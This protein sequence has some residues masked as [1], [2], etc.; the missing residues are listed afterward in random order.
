MLVTVGWWWATGAHAAIVLKT[1][2]ICVELHPSFANAVGEDGKANLSHPAYGARFQLTDALSTY[3]GYLLDETGCLD[4]YPVFA[5][6]I[7]GTLTLRVFTRARLQGIDVESWQGADHRGRKAFEA[8]EFTV[9]TGSKT[10]FT[11]KST[12]IGADQRW[13]NL[14]I[15]T[16]LFWN[17]QWDIGPE[18]RQR[19]TP[20]HLQSDPSA[21]AGSC[22]RGTLRDSD[23]I[24]GNE[25]LGLTTGTD[26]P[27]RFRIAQQVRHVLSRLHE[28]ATN[29]W[30]DCGR[31]RWW[32]L[33]GRAGPGRCT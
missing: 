31:H 13:R 28:R 8:A 15:A 12:V 24:L 5:E 19:I 18:G 3:S 22:C 14:S 2:D 4:D 23:D 20:I 33:I 7:G 11:T 26:A 1:G 16:D 6:E 30:W 9:S 29:G 32:W 17:R 27:Y 25:P 21:R 10:E